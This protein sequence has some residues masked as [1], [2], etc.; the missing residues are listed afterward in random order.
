MVNSVACDGK[1][2][3]EPAVGPPNNAG[4][5]SPED[6]AELALR[7]SERS[8]DAWTAIYR[9][10]STAIF[11]YAHARVFDIETA[12]DLTS[13]VFSQ[14]IKGA[15]TYRY[16][17]RPILAWLY[18]IARNEVSTHQRRMLRRR[19]I[20]PIAAISRLRSR[21]DS[22]DEPPVVRGS[23]A[24]DPSYTRTMEEVELRDAVMRLS[25]AQREVMVLR[26]FVGLKTPQ[27]A[28]VVGKEPAAVYSL[29]ARAMDAL[30][31]DLA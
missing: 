30:R 14:A 6:E 24:A 9:Q 8:A 7:A 28:Q 18:R 23:T 25:D 13:A 11:R 2:D 20:A 15:G 17:G 16:R 5:W 1:A 29:Q 31:R 22:G 3:E 19:A 10:H 12:E 4:E 27:I 21:G 26:W